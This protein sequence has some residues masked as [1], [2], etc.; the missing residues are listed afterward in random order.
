[1]ENNKPIPTRLSKSQM[2][3]IKK[4]CEE[5]IHKINED[6][7]NRKV[8]NIDEIDK[9]SVNLQTQIEIWLDNNLN[10]IYEHAKCIV[11]LKTDDVAKGVINSIVTRH[12]YLR[13]EF[14]KLQ[15][16]HSSKSPK[17]PFNT[18]T[19]IHVRQNIL[20]L[21]AQVEYLK[22]EVLLITKKLYKF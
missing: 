8:S 17:T 2:Q 11:P 14:L 3:E 10:F 16:P 19:I 21:V 9:L 6:Y 22:E 5:E 1:L 4:T 7:G 20:P 13:K 15:S 12:K 18:A